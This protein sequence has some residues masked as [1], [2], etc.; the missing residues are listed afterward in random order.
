MYGL[1]DPKT[2]V[3]GHELIPIENPDPI[4]VVRPRAVFGAID[5]RIVEE[6]HTFLHRCKRII[7]V[8]NKSTNDDTFDFD[9]PFSK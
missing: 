5:P 3:F 1:Q 4:S 7:M 8:S 9:H 2:P 6:V